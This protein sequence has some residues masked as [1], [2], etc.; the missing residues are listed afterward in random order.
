MNKREEQKEERRNQILE[1]SLDLFVERG[2][3]GTKVSD[4][5]AAAEMSAG[6]FFHYFD[7]KE[8]VYEELVN[9]GLSGTQISMQTEFNDPIEFFESVANGI[10]SAINSNRRIAKMFVLMANAQVDKS[11]PEKI[12]QIA[13]K[14]NN[15]QESIALIEEGQR[16][17]SIRQGN[18]AELSI[19]FW[20]AVQGIA[21]F[22]AINPDAPCPKSEWIVDILRA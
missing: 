1:V 8:Q 5:S 11:S 4:I 22:V 6:L 15:I 13:L 20:C 9:L 2:F 17:G 14:V 10:F 21:T 7:S 18:P 3:S 12:R 19:A 16:I